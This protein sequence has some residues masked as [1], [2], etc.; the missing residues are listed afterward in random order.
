MCMFDALGTGAV[1]SC[2]PPFGYQELDLGPL[3]EQQMLLTVEPSL[4]SRFGNLVLCD[5]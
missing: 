3:P 5:S 2:E 4:K 1:G